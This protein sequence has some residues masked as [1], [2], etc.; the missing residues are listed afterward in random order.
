MKTY[1]IKLQFVEEENKNRLM[2]TFK[3]HQSIWNYL[4]EY[5]FKTRLELSSKL[6]HE[7]T[8]YKCKKNISRFPISNYY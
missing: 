5:L 3:I 2:E 6:L 4:S 7:K 8:Y 1:N